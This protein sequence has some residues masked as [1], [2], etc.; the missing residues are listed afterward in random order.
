MITVALLKIVFHERASV[1]LSLIPG[2]HADKR[3]VP[4][5][6]S[7]VVRRHLF[8]HRKEIATGRCRDRTFQDLA[9]SFLIGMHSGGGSQR[10][11]PA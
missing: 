7:R 9:Q 2:V 11:A 5:R 3:Q 10:A 4:V 1:A 6:L 8:E